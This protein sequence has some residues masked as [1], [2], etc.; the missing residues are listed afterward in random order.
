[1]WFSIRHFKSST[2]EDH[3][4]L[5]NPCAGP[6][7]TACFNSLPNDKFSDWSELKEVTDDKINAAENVKFGSG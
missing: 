3:V 5:V 7:L 6:I 2:V 1:M 4:K